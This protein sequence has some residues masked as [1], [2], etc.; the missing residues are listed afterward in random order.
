MTVVFIVVGV[1]GNI[2]KKPFNKNGGTCNPS[3]NQDHPKNDITEK[4]SVVRRV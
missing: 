3:E 4:A 2:M 1:L